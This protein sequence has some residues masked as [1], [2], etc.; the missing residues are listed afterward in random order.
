MRVDAT[1]TPETNSDGERCIAAATVTLHGTGSIGPLAMNNGAIGGGAFGLQDGI[2]GL[3]SFRDGNGNWQ[4]AWMPVSGL[5]N[6]GLLIR[7]WG[8]VTY[9]DQHTFTIDDGSGQ[10]VKCVT[11]SDV[12]VDPAW[13]YIGVIGVSSCEKIGEELH[14]LIRIR[15]QEDIA[16][17]Q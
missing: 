11:P 4:W 7:T 9:V 14:R 10:H 5:N 3:Q 13:T 2:W 12:T 16:S 1:G 17:Y 15:K 8:R 6:I